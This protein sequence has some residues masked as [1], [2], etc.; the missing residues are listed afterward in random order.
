MSTLSENSHEIDEALSVLRANIDQIHTVREWANQFDYSR[1]YFHVLI[2]EQFNTT[3]YEII[4]KEK[5]RRLKQLLEKDS[6]RKGYVLAVEL[7]FSD[8][9]SLHKFLAH[10]FD[11]NLTQLR[12]KSPPLMPIK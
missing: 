9:K 8:T 1:T 6:D 7:G 3:P 5:L 10:N 2:K 4:K 11:T 12:E